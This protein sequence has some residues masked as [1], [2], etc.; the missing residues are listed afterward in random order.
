MS[1][2]K[3]TPGPWVIK[4]GAANSDNNNTGHHLVYP[5]DS[6]EFGFSDVWFGEFQFCKD[7]GE[8]MA[9]AKLIAAAP[10][11]I[12]VCMELEDELNNVKVEFPEHT[13]IILERMK[14]VIK[15]AT[16]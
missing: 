5:K 8:A 11:L 12:D 3:H 2:T 15:K 7:A 1:E 14:D 13:W 10:D 6:F 4:Q 9:N 16:T